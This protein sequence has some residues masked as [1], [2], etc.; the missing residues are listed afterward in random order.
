MKNEM[1]LKKGRIVVFTEAGKV[2]A[3]DFIPSM[4]G[5]NDEIHICDVGH[6]DWHYK[7]DGLFI[8]A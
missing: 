4:N 8:P 3:A 1:N 2:A 7:N 5:G 6:S